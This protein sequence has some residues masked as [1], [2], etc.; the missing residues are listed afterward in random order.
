M[1]VDSSALL[2]VLLGESDAP[3]YADALARPGRK[4]MSSVSR[5]ECGIVVEARKGEAGAKAFARLV[6]LGGIDTVAFDAGQ[7]EIAVDAWRRFGKGRHP[8][9]LNMGDC[10]SYAL[11]KLLGESLLWKGEDFSLTDLAPALR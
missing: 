8:A 1:V 7:S 2:A 10:A 6:A 9:A 11:A 3:D 5:M 4:L